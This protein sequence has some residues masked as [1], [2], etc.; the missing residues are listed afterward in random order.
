MLAK[1]SQHP[2][3]SSLFCNAAIV[4]DTARMDGQGG[5]SMAL[6]LSH[7]T[8]QGWMGEAA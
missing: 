3:L 4:G 6:L 7:G 2:C 1:P 8:E 5:L